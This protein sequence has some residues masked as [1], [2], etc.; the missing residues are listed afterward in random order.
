MNRFPPEKIASVTRYLDAYAGAVAT[1]FQ[2]VDRETLEQATVLLEKAY[3]DG[4]RIYVCGNG[5]SASISE[6]FA[7]DHLKGARTTTALKPRVVSLA[8]NLPLITAI[9]NDLSYAQIFEYQLENLG[10]AGD[11]LVAIS[12]S[13]NSENVVRAARA[14]KSLGM[15]TIGMVGFDGGEL[16]RAAD[17]VLH[18][19]ADNYGVIEDCHQSLMHIMAQFI[20][21]RHLAA[22]TDISSLRF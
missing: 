5:G 20:R 8:S 9:S 11:L 2:S 13:G 6:H 10:T 7:C 14:A 12:C 21:M 18:V 17:F 15:R 22:G 19:R 3:K 1:A 16:K 4:N